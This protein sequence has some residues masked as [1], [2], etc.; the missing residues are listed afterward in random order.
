[1]SSSKSSPPAT[2]KTPDYGGL[3][4]FLVEP[5]LES[6]ASLSVDC[7]YGSTKPQVWVRVAFDES[8][9]ARVFG[10]GGRNID[11]IRHSLKAMAQTAGHSLVLDV[12]GGVEA[13]REHHSPK[14]RNG[15]SSDRSSRSPRRRPRSNR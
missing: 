2:P 3:V 4:R 8:D 1:M 11:A 5:F 9:R 7:E 13:H 15:R 12:F 14:P 10:R 6:P